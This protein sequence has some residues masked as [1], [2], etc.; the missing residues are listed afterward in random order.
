ME[1][2]LRRGVFECDGRWYYAHD[3]GTVS[4]DLAEGG[5]ETE[6]E[7]C[8]AIEL[9][10]HLTHRSLHEAWPALKAVSFRV[11]PSAKGWY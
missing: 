5:V 1:T 11:S 8:A 10:A 6:D 3:L 7:L 2:M 9:V 4:V